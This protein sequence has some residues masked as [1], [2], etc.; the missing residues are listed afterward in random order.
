MDV[1]AKIP[2]RWVL[3]WTGCKWRKV[4]FS[5][6]KIGDRIRIF[7]PDG[8]PVTCLGTREL[9]VTELP[10]FDAALCSWSVGATSLA[11]RDTSYPDTPVPPYLKVQR[12]SS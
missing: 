4:Q 11:A 3:R 2:F 1:T 8:A 6:L 5:T 9:V 12:K 10:E 7:E